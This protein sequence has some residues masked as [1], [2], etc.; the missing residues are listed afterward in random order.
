[1][2]RRITSGYRISYDEIERMPDCGYDTSYGNRYADQLFLDKLYIAV[3]IIRIKK[4]H[5][6]LAVCLFCS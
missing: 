3:C 5:S 2:W 6:F 1:M 4:A